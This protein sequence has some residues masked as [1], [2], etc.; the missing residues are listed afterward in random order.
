MTGRRAIPLWLTAFCQTIL[1]LFLA[2]CGGSL[3]IEI[4]LTPTPAGAQSTTP[5]VTPSVAGTPSPPGTSVAAAVPFGLIYRTGDT[6]WH[7][8]ANGESVRIVQGLGDGVRE[9]AVSP[10]GT[11]VLYA[12]GEDIWWVD[13]ATGERRNVTQTP[14]RSE[15]CAQ[16]WPNRP[17]LILFNSWTPE[18][19]GLNLGFATVASL[20]GRQYQVLDHERVSFVL[21]APSPDGRTVAYDREGQP[22]L[23]RMDTGPE[24]FLFDLTPHGPV[25][26]TQLS[27]VS[28]AWSPDGSRLAWVVGGSFAALGG[29]R[30]GTG[31][32]DFDARMAM[33]LHPYEPQGQGG[34]PSAPRWNPDGRW[35]VFTA[36]AQDDDEAGTWVVNI[37]GREHHLGQCATPVWSPD[38]QW[39][40]C[41]SRPRVLGSGG[42]LI[43]VGTWEV[44]SLE[45]PAD[46]Q[47]VDWISVARPDA[48]PANGEFPVSG[49][50]PGQ[51]VQD[52]FAP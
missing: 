25:S 51:G 29:W 43:E 49:W 31:V 17:D 41:T 1:L 4:L 2:G 16:W 5:S 11:Q 36:W 12:D 38:G 42:W 10:G 9:P 21:P 45:L 28:P 30:V 27:V 40:A 39:L 52:P 24:P 50:E 33:L 18:D 47:L 35:L 46:A 15:C 44:H 14:E 3:E 48:V 20:D 22:W 7:I 32:Y 23:Y 37:D 19:A 8:N 13:V 34:W 26:D 6:L